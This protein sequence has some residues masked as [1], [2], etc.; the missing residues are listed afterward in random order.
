MIQSYVWVCATWTGTQEAEMVAAPSVVGNRIFV[1]QVDANATGATIL[2]LI[3]H[4]TT[5]PLYSYQ[6]TAA[7]NAPMRWYDHPIC[8]AVNVP[9]VMHST[10]PVNG[11]VCALIAVGLGQ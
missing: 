3:D 9:L 11:Q 2:T 7:G 4:V 1:R 5:L 10:Q 6:F 8:T